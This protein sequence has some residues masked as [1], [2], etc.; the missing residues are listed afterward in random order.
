MPLFLVRRASWFVCYATRCVAAAGGH[1]QVPAEQT[2]A[3]APARLRVPENHLPQQRP[4]H[5]RLYLQAEAHYRTEAA[6]DHLQSRRD[7]QL[8]RD[9]AGGVRHLLLLAIE[10]VETAPLLSSEQKRDIFYNNAARFLRLSEE[11]MAKH[12]E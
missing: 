9:R 6:E 12:R 10:A 3:P 4:A 11:Q 5:R 8:R 2:A 7:G 1:A